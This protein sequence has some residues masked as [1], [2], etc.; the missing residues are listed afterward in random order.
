MCANGETRYEGKWVHGK[1]H[2]NGRLIYHSN[3]TS[4]YDG[5]W[6]NNMKHGYGI[7]VYKYVSTYNM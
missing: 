4:Y 3:G 7:E 2:G 6:V 1:R 5:Q